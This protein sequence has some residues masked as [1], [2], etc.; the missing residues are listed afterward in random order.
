MQ[1]VKGAA[2]LF[3]CLC[4][5]IE[6]ALPLGQPTEFEPKLGRTTDQAP[7]PDRAND[8]GLQMGKASGWDLWSG[9]TANRNTVCQALHTH[10]SEPCFSSPSLADSSSDPHEAIAK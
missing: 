5:V 7:W 2:D 3:H 9:T 4:G 6:W 8:S 1:Q 10:Y